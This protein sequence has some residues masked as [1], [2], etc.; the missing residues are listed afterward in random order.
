MPC[1]LA[2]FGIPCTF[3]PIAT[4]E[5][6]VSQTTER[7]PIDFESGSSEPR[8]R[9]PLLYCME[10]MGSVGATVMMVVIFFYMQ[11]NFHWTAF[12][13]LLLAA[14]EGVVYV[15]GALSTDFLSRIIGR[16]K[17][18][19]VLNVGMVILGVLGWML[20]LQMVVTVMALAYT[21]LSATQWPALESLVSANA[22]AKALS[23]RLAI[24]NLTWSGTN[25]TTAALGG[26]II[27]HRSS[28]I[29][30]IT[31]M[32][33]VVALVV[34]FGSPLRWNFPK[35]RQVAAHAAPEVELVKMRT[36]AMQLSRVALPATYAAIYAL[37]A[38]MPTLPVIKAFAPSMRTVI[39]SV[40]MITRFFIFV[41]LGATVWW[42]TR[43]RALLIAIVAMA[44][45]FLA[46]TVRPSAMLPSLTL[47]MTTDV[48][49]MIIAQLVLGVAMGLIYCG[50][51]YFGMVLSEGSTE[52]GGYHEALI[53]AGSILGPG[54]GALTQYAYGGSQSAATAG[55][56]VVLGLSILASCWVSLH[57]RRRDR[58]PA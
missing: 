34:S 41:V 20:P 25:A 24:Y 54:I 26:F 19:R 33:H 21:L 48:N 1:T 55:V 43:P 27:A 38:M 9:L 53:G 12:Q 14:G 2:D 49:V 28:D 5:H 57:Y 32:A 36:L 29:F 39:A 18:L 7:T 37:N 6:F 35:G 16:R 42:H 51:L 44:V 56:A 23:H 11:K 4:P 15:I 17:L 31:A 52:H 46:I 58:D 47:S 13:N 30:L 3:L 45:A 8:G 10:S 50:S 22:N 40:W